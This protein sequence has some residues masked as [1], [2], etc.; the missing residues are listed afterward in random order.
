[1]GSINL[2]I[3]ALMLITIDKNS[4][5]SLITNHIE[6]SHLQ[7]E[8]SNAIKLIASCVHCPK[9]CVQYAKMINKNCKC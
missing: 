3:S 6:P 5:N 2:I 7:E 4:A 1:M 8:T 9:S